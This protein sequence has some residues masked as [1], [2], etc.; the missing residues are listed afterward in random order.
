MENANM[1]YVEINSSQYGLTFMQISLLW[2]VVGGLTNNR[3]ELV[4]IMVWYWKI[5]D[6]TLM[7]HSF[8]KRPGVGVTKPIFSVPLFS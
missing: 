5:D 1:F 7:A 2:C 6:L 4:Q 8:L 3:S